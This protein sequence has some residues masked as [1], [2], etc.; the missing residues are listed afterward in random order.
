ML[1]V[2]SNSDHLFSRRPSWIVDSMSASIQHNE[3]FHALL[4]D[5]CDDM[6]VEAE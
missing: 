4:K 1:K 5:L 6:G 2:H 3:F